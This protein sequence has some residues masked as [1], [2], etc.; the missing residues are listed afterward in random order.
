[1][2]RNNEKNQA[3]YYENTWEPIPRRHRVPKSFHPKLQT[4]KLTPRRVEIAQEDSKIRAYNHY[5]KGEATLAEL[6]YLQNTFPG[7]VISLKQ[8]EVAR[9]REI[10]E[11]NNTVDRIYNKLQLVKP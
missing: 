2:S 8:F 6:Y 11:T 4:S 7:I 3:G 10:Q 5:L 1:M 9:R